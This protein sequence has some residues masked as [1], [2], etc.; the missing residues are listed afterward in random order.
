MESDARRLDS[1]RPR[2]H[3]PALSRRRLALASPGL[4]FLLASA[5]A[6][7]QPPQPFVPDITER[8]GLLMRFAGTPEVPAARPA[9]R[10][11]LQH[12]LR[13]QRA[14]QA[15]ELVQH[16]GTVRAGDEDARHRRA[17][18]PT[19]TACPARARSTR[20]AGPGGGRSGSSRA[21]APV[22]ARRDVLRVSAPTCRS[23]TSTR[24]RRALGPIRTRSTSTGCT[25][26]ESARQSALDVRTRGDGSLSDVPIHPGQR[27]RSI[28]W[29]WTRLRG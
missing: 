27:R 11:L 2:T 26:A 20:R 4:W 8:S 28:A 15:P 21:G 1:K 17:S 18:I 24:S 12:P 22:A 13:R 25:A 5:P 9:S 7:G 19:S 23:T 10:L 6:W 29:S 16:P 3:W 14:G